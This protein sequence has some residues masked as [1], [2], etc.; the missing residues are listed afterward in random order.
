MCV[1][2]QLMSEIILNVLPLCILH[3]EMLITFWHRMNLRYV[4][5]DIDVI[6]NVSTML[7]RQQSLLWN[8]RPFGGNAVQIAALRIKL[9]ADGIWRDNNLCL[10]VDRHEMLESSRMIAMSVRDKHIVNLAEV[11]P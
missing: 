11:F 6:A 10:F 9:S 4:C 1:Q 8:F 3:E 7:N 2:S 5:Y